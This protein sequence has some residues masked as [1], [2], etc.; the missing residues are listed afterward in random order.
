[1]VIQRLLA[2][3]DPLNGAIQFD[4]KKTLDKHCNK[5]G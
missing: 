2:K 4:K 1:M 3:N 5:T